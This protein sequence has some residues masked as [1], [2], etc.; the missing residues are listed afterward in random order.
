MHTWRLMTDFVACY[1]RGI[2]LGTPAAHLVFALTSQSVF[3]FPF[4]IWHSNLVT[5]QAESKLENTE[6]NRN[7]APLLPG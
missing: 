6:G 7:Q 1:Q 2:Q 3:F 5:P 4:F